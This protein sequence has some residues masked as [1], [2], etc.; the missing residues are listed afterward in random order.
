MYHNWQ[1]KYLY[2]FYPDKHSLSRVVVP[3]YATLHLNRNYS[4]ILISFAWLDFT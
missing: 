3:A 1:I 2:G 4:A